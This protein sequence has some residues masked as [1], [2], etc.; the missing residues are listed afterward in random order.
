MKIFETM[1]IFNGMGSD[2]IQL[3]NLLKEV[4]EVAGKIYDF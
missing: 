1:G 3:N 2:E 4:I